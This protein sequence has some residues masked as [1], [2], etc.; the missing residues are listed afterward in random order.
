MNRIGKKSFGFP[1]G[2][3]RNKQDSST[4]GTADAKPTQ[5]ITTKFSK[6]AI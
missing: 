2:Y 3:D 5:A 1:N 4:K 6:T